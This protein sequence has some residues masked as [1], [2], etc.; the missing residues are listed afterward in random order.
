VN[1]PAA[2]EPAQL[3]CTVPGPDTD[4]C[5]VPGA[6]GAPG[7]TASELP[8]EAI[9]P[10]GPFAVTRNVYGVA[11]TRP[12]KS[13][14]S[15]V[16]PTHPAGGVTTGS[17]VTVYPVTA[18]PPDAGVQLTFT[19]PVAVTCT[20]GVPGTPGTTGLIDADA[21]DAI[22][23]AG[24]FAVTTNVYDTEPL[25]PVKSQVRAATLVQAPTFAGLPDEV[26]V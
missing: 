11:A 14:V 15:A 21:A 6:P 2:G 7:V 25:K 24:P 18:L 22:L 13:Q 12:V 26:T 1:G 5:G 4:T 3:T 9:L 20:V 23:P 17:E 8:A 16:V 19:V 10:A